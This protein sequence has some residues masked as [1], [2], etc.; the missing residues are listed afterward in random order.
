MEPR[1]GPRLNLR[2]L[3]AHRQYFGV[4]ARK[5]RS[6]AA[7]MLARV[8]GLPPERARI[9]TRH[10]RQDFGVDTVEAVA[11]AGELVDAGLLEPRTDLP[12]AYRLTP[13]FAEVASAQIV[14]PLARAHARQIV[15]HAC[16]L[17]AQINAGWTRVPLEIEAIAPFGSYMS[18]DALLDE[19]SLGVVVRARP[20]T[21]RAHWRMA[22]KADG[23]NAVRTAF[24]DLSPFVRVR[25]VTELKSLSRPFSVVFRAD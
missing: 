6:S 7:R 4:E 5:L 10:L 25:L 18:R 12:E 14:E 20:A 24:R 21:R 23:V 13:R 17:A 1:K 15:A 3:L 9:T 16:A 19:L 11:L 2:V 8:A 22:T